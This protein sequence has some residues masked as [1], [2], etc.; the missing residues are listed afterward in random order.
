MNCEKCQDRG[1][2]EK[3]HGLIMV[4]CDCDKAREVAEREGIPWGEEEAPLRAEGVEATY[5]GI[6]QLM[7][8]VIMN[9]GLWPR[10]RRRE[11]SCGHIL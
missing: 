1:F 7:N 4:L 10:R 11:G 5:T 3:E 9:Y 8:T 2:T 6:L